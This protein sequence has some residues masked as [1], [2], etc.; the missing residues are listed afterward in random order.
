MTEDLAGIAI[1]INAVDSNTNAA[2]GSVTSRSAQ[3]TDSHHGMPGSLQES[4][5]SHVEGSQH[6]DQEGGSGLGEVQSV[7]SFR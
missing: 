5:L 6:L 3:L 1:A 2:T 4:A 7:L